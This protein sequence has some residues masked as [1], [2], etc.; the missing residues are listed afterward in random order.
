MRDDQWNCIKDLLPGRKESV[1]V[2]TKDN[3]L[4]CCI[5]IEQE[6]L[7]EIYPSGL[8][9]YRTIHLRHSR[10]SASGVWKQVFE[11]KNADNEYAMIDSTIVRA[12]Q[13][14]AGAKEKTPQK[15]KLLEATQKD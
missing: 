3:R 1:G 11:E 13:Y 8:E 14:R 5:D 2:I 9:I 4:R 12:H 10:W 6:Y 15:T 7:G